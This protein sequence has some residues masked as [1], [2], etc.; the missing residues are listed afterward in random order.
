MKGVVNLAC[1]QHVILTMV[2]DV[3]PVHATILPRVNAFQLKVC[4][5]DRML[6][7]LYIHMS[8]VAGQQQ[9]P[10][11][12]LHGACGGQSTLFFAQ[13]AKAW[14]TWQKAHL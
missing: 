3:Q 8:Y 4:I 14:L 11:N 1:A 6:L 13:P 5:Y 12:N 2:T 10:V 9:L 7:L